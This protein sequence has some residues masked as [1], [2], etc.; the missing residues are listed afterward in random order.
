[1]FPFLMNKKNEAEKVLDLKIK[2]QSVKLSYV[3]YQLGDIGIPLKFSGLRYLSKTK[4]LTLSLTSLQYCYEG[5]MGYLTDE[6]HFNLTNL[7][8]EQ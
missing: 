2:D 3:S 5:Q 1:M 8:D 4:M 6:A 7:L